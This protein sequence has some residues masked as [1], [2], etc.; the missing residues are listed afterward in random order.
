MAVMSSA[1]IFELNKLSCNKKCRTN[2]KPTWVSV[3]IVL[4]KLL[5][6]KHTV[7]SPEEF[8]ALFHETHT[9]VS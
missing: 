5:G 2:T 7:T 3:E 9:S 8:P 4:G 1:E 6:L